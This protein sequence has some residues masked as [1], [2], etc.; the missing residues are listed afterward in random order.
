V[1][2]RTQLSV[3]SRL[4]SEGNKMSDKKPTYKRHEDDDWIDEVRIVTVPRYKTSGL[5]G[6][7]WRFSA[8]VQFLR[9]GHVLHER[10]FSKI[11]YAIDF[12]PAMQHEYADQGRANKDANDEPIDFDRYCFSPGCKQDGVVE[13]EL[14]DEYIPRYGIKEEKHSWRGSVRRRF[15]EQHARRGDCGL[16][17]SDRNYVLISAPPG[18]KGNADLG[19]KQ[20]ES[21]SGQVTVSIDSL[22]DLP[23]AIEQ[24]RKDHD[25]HKREAGEG[26]V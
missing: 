19:A 17:D 24:A 22:D 20:A 6:D 7:E 1:G 15:C 12:L 25:E 5:S 18:W 9:K 21:A 14:I 23:A 4:K 2:R 13:Y 10:S 16:E 8:Q 26:I 11:H 3:F